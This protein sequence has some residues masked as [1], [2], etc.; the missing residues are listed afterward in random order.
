MSLP[1]PDGER[2]VG[3]VLHET[4]TDAD[5]WLTGNSVRRVTIDRVCTV[6]GEAEETLRECSADVQLFTS[7][8]QGQ[9]VLFE[10]GRGATIEGSLVEKCRF[11]AIVARDDGSVMAI[12]FRRL[13]PAQ[14]P[15]GAS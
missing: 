9:R 10:D 4:A 1:G 8:T 14:G 3:V 2:L 15:R 7:L 13:W 11:G 5:V 12:G 6:H